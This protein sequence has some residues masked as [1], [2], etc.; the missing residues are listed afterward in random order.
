MISIEAIAAG[1]NAL[2]PGEQLQQWDQFTWDLDAGEAA[3]HRFYLVLMPLWDRGDV[4]API[5]EAQ[6]AAREAE[7]AAEALWEAA[8]GF[9]H[10]GTY[11]TY[12]EPPF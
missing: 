12:G 5:A 1:W 6:L 3:F 11:D 8:H 2:S 7:F 9:R 10:D 4:P